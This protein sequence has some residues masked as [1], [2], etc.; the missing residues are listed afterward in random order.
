MA[1]RWSQ[2]K[3]DV[4][5]LS[6]FLKYD[7]F[8]LKKLL[9]QAWLDSSPSHTFNTLLL[10]NLKISKKFHNKPHLLE[11]PTCSKHAKMLILNYHT[12]FLK[13]MLN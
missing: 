13:K 6:K 3:A 9:N 11:L 7:T 12:F 5:N 10:S 4:S 1:H 2:M 8:V